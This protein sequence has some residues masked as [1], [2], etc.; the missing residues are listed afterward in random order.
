MIAPTA[1]PAVTFKNVCLSYSAQAVLVDLSL[2][3]NQGEI[4]GVL[5]RVGAGKTRILR[6]IAGLE[7]PQSG[8]I[9]YSSEAIYKPTSYIFQDDT[10]IPWLNIE[11]NLKIC[12]RNDRVAL[13]EFEIGHLLSKKPHELSG[14]MRQRVNFIRAFINGDVI[15]LM[16]E[17]F[18]ALDPIQRLSL[19]KFFLKAQTRQ[20]N[21]AVFVTHDIREAMLICNRIAL[22]STKEKRIVK[23]IENPY[24]GKL[25]EDD[26]FNQ[27][28]Y[29]NIFKSIHSF[30][31]EDGPGI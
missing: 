27:S 25:D 10:L 4:L 19:Q 13:D 24:F 28:D 14:G 30:F 8:K 23:T 20:K 15:V 11:E 5:G 31:E 21:S 3:L 17:P 22:L 6:L 16:D 9:E 1:R 18:G 26:L 2:E 29:R 12:S 7:F